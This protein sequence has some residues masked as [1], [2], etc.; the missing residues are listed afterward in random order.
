MT[1]ADIEMQK[2][3]A[4]RVRVLLL[5]TVYLTCSSDYRSNVYSW[6]HPQTKSLFAFKSHSPFDR[7]V[8]RFS[9]YTV[10]VWLRFLPRNAARSLLSPGVRPMVS[11]SIC[12]VGVLY[13]HGW[14][15]CQISFSAR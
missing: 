13:R 15:Y 11:P 1:F 2:S 5:Y 7:Y 12:Y 9:E 14:T 8:V 3:A 6:E 4:M 10:L